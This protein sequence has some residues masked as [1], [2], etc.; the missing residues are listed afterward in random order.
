MK[1][2]VPCETC[3]G[4]VRMKIVVR[5]DGNIFDSRA[6]NECQKCGVMEE[7]KDVIVQISHF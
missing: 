5:Y 6:Y 7:D 2:D 4:T 1:P 3:G